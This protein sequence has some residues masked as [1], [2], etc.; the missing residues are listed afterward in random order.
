MFYT[1]VT[2]YLRQK[3]S[4]TQLVHMTKTWRRKIAKKQQSHEEVTKM[5]INGSSLYLNEEYVP[6]TA[7]QS[8]SSI[9]SLKSEKNKLKSCAS[10][11]ALAL[12]AFMKA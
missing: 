6:W 12:H 7:V 10:L 4:N 9:F 5:N 11:R 1:L 2:V 8:E 3:L